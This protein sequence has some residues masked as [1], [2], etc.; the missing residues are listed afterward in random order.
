MR[1]E[2]Q[3]H[4][5]FNMQIL[6]NGVYER[7]WTTA[8][9]RKIPFSEVTH[10]HW[11]NIYW[12]H[13]YIYERGQVNELVRDSFLCQN[14]LYIISVSLGQINELHS[15]IMLDW[16]P[17]YENEKQWYALQNTRKVLIEK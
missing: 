8:D 4:L 5:T 2:G 3:K 15:G 16:V 1:N 14:A 17:K 10:Q 7:H 9:G 12:Y 11:S 6:N 13:R